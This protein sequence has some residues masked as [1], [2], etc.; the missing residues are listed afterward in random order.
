MKNSS[1][2]VI[3]EWTP[4]ASVDIT[5]RQAAFAGQSRYWTTFYHP[6]ANYQLPAGAQAFTMGA[7]HAPN[8]RRRPCQVAAST[9]RG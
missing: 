7:D 4:S 3:A 1:V 6:S 2:T 5:A 9:G 8:R